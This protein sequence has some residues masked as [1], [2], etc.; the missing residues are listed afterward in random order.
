MRNA[1]PAARP[2]LVALAILLAAFSPARAGDP[3][4]AAAEEAKQKEKI[5]KAFLEAATWFRDKARKPEAVKAIAEAKA[6]DPKVAG[7]DALATAV[8]A[9]SD[10]AG[11]DPEAT[12]KWAKAAADAAKAY[13]KLATVEHDAKD[14]TRFDGYLLRAVELEPSKAR[15]AKALGLAR[16][17]AGNK[18]RAASAGLLLVR[19]RD[20]DPDPAGKKAADAAT[21]EMA[22][23]DVALVKS[24]D[25][26]MVA[27]LSLPKG[28]TA[29]GECPVL[30]TVDRAGANFLGS[31]RAFRDARG[32]RK[33]MVL[34][35]CSFSNTNE[36]KT[37]TYPFYAPSLLAEWDGKRLDFD[38]PGLEA[39][40]KTLK[41][42]YGAADK[43]A[44][45]GFSGGGNLCYAWTMRH[46]ERVLC[47]APA[48]AN[49][50][51]GIP[52]DAAPVTGGGP[53]VHQ[54]TGEKDEYREEVHGQKPGIEGQADGAQ[55]AFT[56]L[57]FTHVKRT[58]LPGV[59]HSSCVKE[60]WSFV[61]EVSGSK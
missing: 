16:L 51:A 17:A 52:G 55:E 24:P 35:P 27:W 14:D 47:S 38:V 7:L 54:F 45:T 3:M 40:L 26:P 11:D 19:L 53:P 5:A 34:A 57:G 9:L 1:F 4:K 15:C 61:D 21:A 29:K 39:I 12:A 50:N 31:A 20:L 41:E 25:H 2:C 10:P 56:K 44:I 48:C 22:Q 8:D 6:A 13:E 36:L 30:V 60:V 42:R 43:V 33:F 37:E 58:M 18:A 59:G 32:S 46:P 28:W 49:F 23:S